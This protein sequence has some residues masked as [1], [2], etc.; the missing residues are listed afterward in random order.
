MWTRL[1]D[2]RLM[3][4][5]NQFWSTMLK[6][7]LL[8]AFTLTILLVAALPSRKVHARPLCYG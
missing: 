7:A 1:G 3:M 6:L 2:F 8:T 5:P 4:N